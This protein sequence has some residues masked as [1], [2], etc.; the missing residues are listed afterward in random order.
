[1]TETR[2]TDI[3]FNPVMQAFTPF[4]SNVESSRLNMQ[5]KYWNQIV[6]SENVKNPFIVTPEVDKLVMQ[7]DHFKM[8]APEDCVKIFQGHDILILYYLESKKLMTFY[9]PQYQ[10]ASG[11]SYK[12]FYVNPAHKIK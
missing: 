6:T 3:L 12:L 4:A 9:I 11:A 8:R 2:K 1:M 7:D 10:D 5:A